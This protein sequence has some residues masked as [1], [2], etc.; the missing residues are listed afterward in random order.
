MGAAW[1]Y[2]VGTT[3][4]LVRGEVSR[5][6]LTPLRTAKE[7]LTTA[8]L[9]QRVMA[10]RGLNTADKRLVKTM[11]K[12]VGACLRDYRRKGAD[13][14]GDRIKPVFDVVRQMKVAQPKTL[15]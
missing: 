4:I 9:A 14:V 6:V 3:R 15:I 1:C 5:V 8:D 10:E 12:R 13:T 2:A 11:V 7:P